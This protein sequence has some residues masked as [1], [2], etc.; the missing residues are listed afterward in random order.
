MK[1]REWKEKKEDERR[2]RCLLKKA[3]LFFSDKCQICGKSERH[4]AATCRRR[5]YLEIK[6]CEGCRVDFPGAK[7]LNGG[8]PFTMAFIS[9]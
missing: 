8:G 3:I 7:P 2:K 1:R 9:A 6:I 4:Y 5:G